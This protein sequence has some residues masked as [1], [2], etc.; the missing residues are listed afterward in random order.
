MMYECLPCAASHILI[1]E[2]DLHIL[3]DWH[4]RLDDPGAGVVPTGALNDHTV[5]QQAAVA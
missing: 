2:S 4:P 3:C 1:A 5:R